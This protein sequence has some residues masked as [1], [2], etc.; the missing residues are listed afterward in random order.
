AGLTTLE[1]EDITALDRLIR[2]QR[3]TEATSPGAPP[4]DK[5]RAERRWAAGRRALELLEDEQDIDEVID[6]ILTRVD[7]ALSAIEDAIDDAEAHPGPRAAAA[8]LAL[9]SAGLAGLDDLEVDDDGALRWRGLDPAELVLCDEDWDDDLRAFADGADR[10]L[11]G[12][13]G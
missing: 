2:A 13:A 3:S 10:L 1:V 5:V 11:A 12:Q 8:L 4:A 6:G 9:Q 7:G